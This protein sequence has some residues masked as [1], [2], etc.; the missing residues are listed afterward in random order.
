MKVEKPWGWYEVLV[1]IEGATVKRLV[2]NPGER[3]SKQYHQH[4]KE[5][6]IPH[7]GKGG[8]HL[9]IDKGPD[10]AEVTVFFNKPVIVKPQHKHRIF[11]SKDSDGPLVLIEVWQGEILDE[12]DNIRLEDDYGRD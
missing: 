2:I 10:A 5:Y 7:S 4:R 3:L 6:L 1:E 8:V 9:G 11:A 12:N